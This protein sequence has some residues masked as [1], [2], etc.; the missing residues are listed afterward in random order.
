MLPRDNIMFMI[1]DN[2]G[3]AEEF[4]F[5]FMMVLVIGKD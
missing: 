4:Y 2:P 1:Q 5:I 3:D